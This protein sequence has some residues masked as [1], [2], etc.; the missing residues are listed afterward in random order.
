M[1][2]KFTQKPN[3]S[4]N[5]QVK[6]KFPNNNCLFSSKDYEDIVRSYLGGEKTKCY[7]E[8]FILYFSQYF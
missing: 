5:F 6:R 3:F 7:L 4:L 1:L 2:I 8:D